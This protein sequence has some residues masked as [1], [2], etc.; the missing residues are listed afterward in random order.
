[1]PT[2]TVRLTSL[3]AAV[4]IA[5]TVS[6]CTKASAP[7][8]PTTPSPTP[9]APAPQVPTLPTTWN[10]DAQGVPQFITDNYIDL[11]LVRGI[12]RFRS[13]EGHDY[14]DAA[15]SCRSMKHYFRVPL[16]S[17]ARSIAI[18]SPV[19]GAIVDVHAEWA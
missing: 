13:G 14:S 1:M 10:I 6:G 7:L 16:D 4:F 17:S 11:S 9:D 12:S 5:V 18:Q 2:T 3:A 15:E 19:T 8:Q